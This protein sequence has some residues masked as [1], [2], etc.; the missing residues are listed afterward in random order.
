MKLGSSLMSSGTPECIL[1]AQHG[2][3]DDN[4]AMAGLATDLVAE[5]PVSTQI[6][7]PYLGYIQ[8]WI[9][10]EPLIR[11]VEETAISYV[12]NYPETP[13]KIVGHSMGGLIWLEVLDRHPD[14]WSRIHSLTLVA[15]PVGGA[16]LGRMIDPFNLG[17]GIAADLGKNRRPIAER[18]AEQIPTLVIAGDLD[19]GSDGTVTI[20]CTKVTHAH[21]VRMPG[22]SH[23]VMR[24]HPDIVKIITQF[25]ATLSFG[26]RLATVPIIQ[27]LRAIPGMTDGHWRDFHR[28]K[29]LFQ[30][31]TGETLRIWKSPFNIYHIFVASEEESCL[32]AGFVGWFHIAELQKALE[33]IA[34]EYGI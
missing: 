33:E 8:T 12:R 13:F 20:E 1:F 15:S 10:I 14:W 25:W 30:L 16:D 26:E 28:S 6:V 3:A 31:K 22:L 24:N 23:P 17:I 2:W 27:H 11:L 18:I 5:S 21:F 29:I 4:R 7:T 34:I 32:Y 9:R 19:G